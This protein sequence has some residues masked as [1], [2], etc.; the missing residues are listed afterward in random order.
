M[1]FDRRST[2]VDVI[3]Y[4]TQVR[5]TM[6]NVGWG[7]LVSFTYGRTLQEMFELLARQFEMEAE[8]TRAE[9]A[10]T[11][12]RIQE[13]TMNDPESPTQNRAEPVGA[14]ATSPPET[15]SEIRD[16]VQNFARAKAFYDCLFHRVPTP[17]AD[18]LT[19]EQ[20][21]L[22]SDRSSGVSVD[23][24]T[25]TSAL[26]L[27]QSVVADQT[28]QERVYV[29]LSNPT[30]TG[31]PPLKSSVCEYHKL[32]D[33]VS[34]EGERT[35]I[36]LQGVDSTARRRMLEIIEE[37]R[38][39]TA[40]S[41]N[42]QFLY[43][44]TG[45]DPG[46]IEPNTNIS[47]PNY[48]A[49]LNDLELQI[50]TFTTTT[51]LSGDKLIVPKAEAESLFNTYTAAMQYGARPICTLNEYIAFLG[52]DADPVGRVEPGSALAQSDPRT[53]AAPYYLSIR[54]YIPGPPPTIPT[55]NLTNTGGISMP[56]GTTTVS[57]S[58]IATQEY[59]QG[60]AV[61]QQVPVGFPENRSDW[62]SILRQYRAN[63]L[64]RLAPGR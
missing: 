6:S 49:Q 54:T 32:I 23:P 64:T 63:V 48:E 5:H 19:T 29:P 35:G 39:G 15:L 59:M 61:V 62:N 3:G 53:F 26:G 43:N 52:A 14:I 51:N 42:L 7:S 18:A 11:R 47:N 34:P 24:D 45:W 57:L 41:E 12:T 22:A 30:G 36:S 2:Q 44:A 28:T 4:V 9:A 60:T 46:A 58:A 40:T 1:V 20:I 21:N 37:L 8:S 10:E 55:D 25:V 13:G 16:V 17:A 31:A 38:R 56:D 33:I 27:G 50:R